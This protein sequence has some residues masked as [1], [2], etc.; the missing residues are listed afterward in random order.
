LPAA[1]YRLAREL[2]LDECD[3]PESGVDVVALSSPR[4]C[5]SR[6]NAGGVRYSTTRIG[7]FF[8]SGENRRSHRVLVET[9]HLSAARA[10]NTCVGLP[11]RSSTAQLF[12]DLSTSLGV[13]M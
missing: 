7:Y 5:T 8:N 2:L 9:D 12:R 1:V 6:A 3:R 11:W 4:H 10:G 13:F